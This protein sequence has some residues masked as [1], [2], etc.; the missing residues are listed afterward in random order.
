MRTTHLTALF[1]LTIAASNALALETITLRSGWISNAPGIPSQIEDDITVLAGPGGTAL[2][3]TAFTPAQFAAAQS[4]PFAR[5]ITPVSGPWI[6]TL[7]ADPLARW[8]NPSFFATG[9]FFLGTPA[10]ALYAVPFNVTTTGITSAT[11]TLH[12]A[13]DD[14]LGGLLAGAGDPNQMGVYINGVPVPIAGGS[15]SS[16]SSVFNVNVTGLVNTGANT[17][18]LYQRDIGVSVS[19]LI[20]S[21]TYNIL[22]APGAAGL[23]GLGGLCAVRRRRPALPARA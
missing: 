4:G 18:Y 22:P 8:I 6:A 16:Q 11:L 23:L 3:A 21:A 17:M 15:F 7:P 19:G 10:S 5:V 1:A 2:S 14:T 9:P 12:W 13:C 20:F